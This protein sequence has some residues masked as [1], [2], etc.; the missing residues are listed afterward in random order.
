MQLVIIFICLYDAETRLICQPSY[1]SMC[2]LTSMQAACWFG[3]SGNAT[4][5]GVAAHLYAEFDGQFI[6][7]QKLHL[8]LQRLYKEHP[9]LRLSLSADGIANIMSEKTQQILEVYDFSKL[10]DYQIEQMLMQKRE[11]WT[12]QKLDLSQG[13]TARFSISVLK[14]N[15]FRFHIDTDMIAID[16]SSFLNLMEDLSLFYEDP[17]ISFSRPPNFFDW[18]QKIRT[19]PDLKKLNQRDRLWWKQRLP[20]ISPAPSLPFIHQEFKT[21]KSDRLSTW[22]SPEERKALQ[23]LAR[24][25]RITVTNLILGLFAYTLGHATKDH[26]FRLNIPTFWREPVLKNV[27]G[28]IGDFANLVILDVDMKGIT[29]LAAFCK[30]IANQMLELLEHSHYSGVN[31]LRDLSRYHGSAQIAPVVFTAALDLEND[32]LLSERVRRVFGSMNWV[33]SQGPQVALDAQV[34]HVDGGILVNWDIRLDALPKEWTTNLFE[35]FIHLLKNLAAHPE[36][37]NTQII[38]SAQNTSSDRTSQKPLNAL[39]Q[40]YLLGR[41]QALPLG[42]VAMQEFRQYHGKMDIVLLRQRLA[43]MVRRHDSLRTYIDKNRF[44]QYVSD[45]VS[46]NLKEID[47]TTWDPEH[48]SHHIQSYKNSY[49]HELFDLNQ[50][51]WNITVFL[52]KNNLLTI[53][54]RFDALILD[55][56][57]IASLM[58]ELFDGQ[59]HDIQTQIEEN[60]A[61]NSLSVHHTDMA[62]WERK[63]SKLSAIPA[64]PWKTPLQHLPTSRYQRKSLVIEKDQFK[65]LSKIGA[66]HSLFKNSIIMAIIL[67][68]LS[69]WSTDKSLCVAVPTL[70]LYA[71][72]FSN[73]STFIAVE[74]K[75]SHQFAEQANRLQ[76]EVLEGLQ[77]LSF[78]GVDLARLL[79]E[80]VGT[81]PVLPIVITNGLSW[82]VLSESHPIQQLDGLTQTPQVAIDIRFSTRNDG[83]L[84]FDIDYAQEAFPPNMIDDFLDALQLAIKQIIGSEIFSFDLSSFFSELQNKRLYF[85]NNESGHSSIPL[86]NNA[87]QQN[88]LLDIYLEVIGHPPN[89]EV[90]NSTHFTHLGLRPHHLKVVSK[91]INEAYAIQLSP[92][93]LIQCRNIAD[94]EKLL[95]AH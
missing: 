47:L 75:T 53:F 59:Q 68:V 36:Q 22:L 63:F 48:A 89:K 74:W 17:E 65:Q 33:I 64:L 87:K 92:V 49:T 40:A 4:L 90:D 60:E 62:Y 45:Q 88:Q 93:Q 70:P 27:E 28:T 55:G 18:Y 37:L 30:Q 72:P 78:S 10:S 11:Q 57:S 6:D 25:Q 69:H 77:H 2:E 41:T 3:R 79:F 34:A 16:P 8:A 24:E 9:I 5:G 76:T 32:N 20:H 1:R 12:H 80:K 85:K 23:Q 82:P 39:Q 83:A 71:G 94:V 91:R 56:L 42:G 95:T 52:L 13:Q 81:A 26:S 19:D 44:V 29:T 61:E 54:V 38:N 50:S 15:I 66:K 7:L 84:I 21:A 67:E 58:L 43:K 51:P 46:V 31:V 14:N 73:S 35:S 86:E